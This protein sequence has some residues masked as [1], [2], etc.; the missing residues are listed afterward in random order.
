MRKALGLIGAAIGIGLLAFALS[1]VGP[2]P[3]RP[4]HIRD[5]IARDKAGLGVDQNWDEVIFERPIRPAD[6]SAF[7]G[8]IAATSTQH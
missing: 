8:L 3:V 6:S 2:A 4:K 7:R 1:L 5:A